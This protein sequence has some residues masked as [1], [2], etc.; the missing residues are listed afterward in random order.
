VASK[1]SPPGTRRTR[2]HII[3]SQSQNYVEKFFI[4]QGH[5]VDRPTDYG[6][7]LLVN[8]FDEDGYPEAGDIRLQLKASDKFKYSKD[9][10]TIVFQIE[11]KHYRYWMKQVMPVFLVLYDAR[12]ARAYWLYVQAYFASDETRKPKERAKSITIRVPIKNRLTRRTVEYMRGRKAA[13]LGSEVQH[14]E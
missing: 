8:T 13:L 9:G 5:T 7:D 14:V 12:K 6:I 11:V 3:A 10:K 4:D 2:E 1:E